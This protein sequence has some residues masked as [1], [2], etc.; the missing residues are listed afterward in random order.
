MMSNHI[1][2]FLFFTFEDE[3]IICKKKKKKAK[4]NN[5]F[6]DQNKSTYIV[7]LFSFCG[8]AN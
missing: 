3:V 7:L 5:V 6:N 8:L 2:L 4:F 1:C